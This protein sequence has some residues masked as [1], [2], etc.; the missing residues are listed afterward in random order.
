M[1]MVRR[2]SGYC[3]AGSTES[4]EICGETEQQMLVWISLLV[5]GME[6][7]RSMKH[8][9]VKINWAWVRG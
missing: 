7:D 4:M 1:C 6:G 5:V 2:Y 8:L 3:G 9:G